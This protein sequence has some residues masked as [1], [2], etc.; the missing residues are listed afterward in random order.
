MPWS[1]SVG[2]KSSP[3]WFEEKWSIGNHL[4]SGTARQS[5]TGTTNCSSTAWKMDE[6]NYS[7]VRSGG[8]WSPTHCRARHRVRNIPG[9]KIETNLR[10]SASLRRPVSAEAHV[11]HW[12]LLIPLTSRSIDPLRFCK[13]LRLGR[14]DHSIS[15]SIR[16]S[17]HSALLF[18]SDPTAARTRL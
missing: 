14:S 12:R 3:R 1:R 8:Q 7:M 15:R 2:S 10:S 4:G 18:T 16:S 11:F 6:T 5:L 17:R 9:Q 13:C